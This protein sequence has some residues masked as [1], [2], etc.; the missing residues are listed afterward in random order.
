MVSSVYVLDYQSAGWYLVRAGDM[1]LLD[2]N[3]NLGA[4]GYS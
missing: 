4:F 2:V 1:L 3:C